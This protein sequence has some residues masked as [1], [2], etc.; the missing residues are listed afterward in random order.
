MVAHVTGLSILLG[1]PL[2]FF[3]VRSYLSEMQIYIQRG[4]KKQRGIFSLLVHFPMSA[5]GR[6]ELIQNWEQ[7]ASYGSLT[8][9]WWGQPPLLSQVINGA[10][11]ELEQP[12][13]QPA[14]IK[15]ASTSGFRVSLLHHSISPDTAF[16]REFSL[17]RVKRFSCH[18]CLVH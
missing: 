7:V 6:A 2:S 1:A 8:R 9:M 17:V 12:G 16:C 14:P 10:G 11:C 15:D 4:N 13:Q 5:M 18:Q 3:S